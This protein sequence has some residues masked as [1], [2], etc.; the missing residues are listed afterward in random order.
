VV[1]TYILFQWSAHH[2]GENFSVTPKVFTIVNNSLCVLKTRKKWGVLCIYFITWSQ[3][4]RGYLLSN[5]ERDI[6]KNFLTYSISFSFSISVPHAINLIQCFVTIFLGSSLLLP[7]TRENVFVFV[8]KIFM[9][10]LAPLSSCFCPS[11][12]VI[13]VHRAH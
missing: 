11:W 1:N 10:L 6:Y 9:S 13:L 3:L 7:I 2:K 8:C 4:D 12:A 5:T